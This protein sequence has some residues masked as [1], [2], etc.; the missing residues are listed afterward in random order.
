MLR[1]HISRVSELQLWRPYL[2]WRPCSIAHFAHPLRRAWTQVTHEQTLLLFN[3]HQAVL[4]THTLHQSN[5]LWWAAAHIYL[6][7]LITLRFFAVGVT[8]LVSQILTIVRAAI[9]SCTVVPQSLEARSPPTPGEQAC[10]CKC[11][12]MQC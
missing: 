3:S 2:F 6:P 10:K 5:N 12:T 1:Q 9:V 7:L 8:G 4:D 11:N